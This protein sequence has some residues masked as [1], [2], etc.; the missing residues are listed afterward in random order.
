VTFL[1]C[2]HEFTE[3]LNQ[4][5]LMHGLTLAGF[6]RLLEDELKPDPH[7]PGLEVLLGFGKPDEPTWR[8]FR[9]EDL[10]AFFAPH[11]QAPRYVGQQWVIHVDTAWHSHYR[12][13]FAETIGSTRADVQVPLFSDLRLIRNDIVHGKGIATAARSGR[14]TVLTD[15]VAVGEPIVVLGENVA[16]FIRLAPSSLRRI[17]LSKQPNGRVS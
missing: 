5:M 10:S 4:S 3:F 2:L 6:R 13:C 8:R 9:R 12:P 16:K 17:A 7:Q 15:W 11:G 1:E 14:C